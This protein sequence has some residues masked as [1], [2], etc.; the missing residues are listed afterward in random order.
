MLDRLNVHKVRHRQGVKLSH[1][2]NSKSFF[3]NH[4]E[5]GPHAAGETRRWC[6]VIVVVDVLVKKDWPKRWNA[7]QAI[8]SKSPSHFAAWAGL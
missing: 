1:G 5:S 7:R 6:C 2:R 3:V 8:Q 4:D